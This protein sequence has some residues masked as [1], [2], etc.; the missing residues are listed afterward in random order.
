MLKDSKIR[1]ST[2]DHIRQELCNAEWAL[3]TQLEEILKVAPTNRKAYEGLFKVRVFQ[4]DWP[5]AH[6]V[7]DRLKTAFPSE[8]TGYYFDGLV[9]Q[10]EKK[11][12]ESIEQFESAL[13]VTPDSIQP[14]SQLIKSHLLN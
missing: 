13:A 12:Q 1:R 6:E 4:K 5:A 7:A 9:Y 10:G 8:P 2:E 3:Q 11:L 14:L